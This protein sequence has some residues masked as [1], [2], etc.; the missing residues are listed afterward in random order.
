[1][2]EVCDSLKKQAMSS[3]QRRDSSGPE[4][5]QRGK[6]CSALLSVRAN[7]ILWLTMAVGLAADLATKAWA[8]RELV[9]PDGITL[10]P[11]VFI[12]RYLRFALVLNPGA[13]GGIA[14][15]QTVFLVIVSLAA[16]VFLIVFFG[17]TR[18]QQKWH[19]FALGMLL[20]GALGN[21]YD[22]ITHDG[23]V[24]DFIEVNLH[25]WPADPWPTFN[26]AD[27][28]LCVGVGLLFG[29]L[30]VPA[31]ARLRQPGQSA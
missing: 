31:V 5:A 9:H 11:I 29:L 25:F 1:M 26:L 15:G 2:A 21:L 8:L 16:L 30:I 14:A 27:V 28:W 6:S 7:L 20:A 23:H 24:V 13:I 19:H 10:D 12:Q 3:A 17:T 22:R 18:A 4:A